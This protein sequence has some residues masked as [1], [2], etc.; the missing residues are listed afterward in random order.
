MSDLPL[1]ST[2]DRR[3]ERVQ[4]PDRLRRRFDQFHRDHPDVYVELVRLAR[5][6]K[7]RGFS[8]YSI[9]GLFEIVRWNVAVGKG[10]DDDFKLNNN[11]S[12]FY[13]RE[14]MRREHDL[15][16]FFQLREQ[17]AA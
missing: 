2:G 10:P 12:A 16:G 15:K 5:Q 3:R 4:S 13:A 17:R 1:F 9:K 14:I 11:L 8:R 7:A 6:V